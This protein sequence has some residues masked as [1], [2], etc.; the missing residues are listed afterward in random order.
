MRRLALDLDINKAAAAL[1]IK[2]AYLSAIEEGRPDQLPGATYAVGFVRSYSE[3]LGL[4]S[5]A[6]L[7]QFKSECAGLN[8]KPDLAFPMPLTEGSLPT[9][10]VVILAIILAASGYGAWYHWRAS[11]Q[12][13]PERVA[14]V[15]AQ[16]LPSKP[17]PR[18]PSKAISAIAADALPAGRV[19][20]RTVETGSDKAGSAA[21]DTVA[22]HRPSVTPE[23]HPLGSG[24][25]TA[26][27]TSVSA[28][29]SPAMPIATMPPP[30]K[31]R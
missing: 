2:A 13:S 5:S 12:T 27:A 26:E 11:E 14:E 18:G 16:L 7:R 1:K 21:S 25:N 24:A 10:R 31:G 4:D 20:D 23:P 8:A 15:P 3:Y 19:S 30:A 29:P 28:A 6:L 9:G 22:A 17:E